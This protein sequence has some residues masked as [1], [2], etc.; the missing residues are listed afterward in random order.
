MDIVNI[1][2]FGLT[3]IGFAVT[4][5]QLI[6]TRK[7]S[8]AALRAAIKTQKSI[9]TKI[10]IS[11]LSS[12]VKIFQEIKESIRNKHNNSAL[13]RLY[14]LIHNIIQ[15]RQLLLSDEESS[16][17]LGKIIIQLKLLADDIEKYN[18][19]D[20]EKLN[21]PIVMHN[22]TDY[23]VILSEIATSRKYSLTEE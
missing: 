20:K 13:L 21:I 5:W 12:I 23:E 3:V 14:D 19:N 2:G 15:M 9:E 10:L 11:D 8:D 17:K 22:L 1:V 16:G 7:A 6:K 4:I 18:E